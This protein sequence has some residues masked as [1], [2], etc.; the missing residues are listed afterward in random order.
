M[1]FSQYERLFHGRT[2]YDPK[3]HRD[4]RANANSKGLSVNEE[5]RRRKVP[6]LS[7]S[8]YGFRQPLE[9]P[10]GDVRRVAIVKSEFFN[11]NRISLN[12]Q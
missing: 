2:N 6:S 4:D 7:S 9:T 12:H 10:N 5:E 8:H 3:M 1:F 11:G